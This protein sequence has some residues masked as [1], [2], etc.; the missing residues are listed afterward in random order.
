MFNA[1]L[2]NL[3]IGAN[4]GT[5][6]FRHKKLWNTIKKYEIVEFFTRSTKT[7]SS[8]TIIAYLVYGVS[9]ILTD[10]QK[11]THYMPCFCYAT[12]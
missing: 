2:I 10:H 9:E 8:Y 5:E 4:D 6:F 11:K 3:L 12:S 7:A 1:E